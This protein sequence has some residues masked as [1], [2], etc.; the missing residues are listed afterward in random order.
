MATVL[1]TVQNGVG[2]QHRP[3]PR[4]SPKNVVRDKSSEAFDI[5][6]T[7]AREAFYIV[8]AIALIRGSLS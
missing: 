6:I 7:I 5:V 4:C 2:R 1:D 8:I 3:F